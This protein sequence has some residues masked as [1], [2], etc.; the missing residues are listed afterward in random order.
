MDLIEIVKDIFT[1][2]NKYYFAHCISSDFALGAGIAAQFEQRFKTKRLLWEQY[3]DYSITWASLNKAGFR[4]DCILIDRVF[5][6]ITKRFYFEKP[7][8]ES[9]KDALKSLKQQCLKYSI[10]YLAMPRIGC[11]LDRLSWSKV[12]ELL[13]EVFNDVDIEILVCTLEDN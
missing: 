7:T 13:K 10:E 2:E 4:G 5:N 1:V 6:L 12:R 11:G 3:P 9:L 8:Y